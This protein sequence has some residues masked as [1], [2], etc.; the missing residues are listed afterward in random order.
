MAGAS[1]ILNNLCLNYRGYGL[2][3]GIM[4]AGSDKTGQR[5]FYIDNDG[6]RLEG[7]LFAVGS[8]G[9]FALGVI[10]THLKK[11]MKDEEAIDLGVRAIYHATHR[12]IASG[13]VCRV[14][15]IHKDGWTRVHDGLDVN[16][17]HWKF[18]EEKGMEIEDDDNLINEFKNMS[19]F[20]PPSLITF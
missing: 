15:H 1:K 6:T 11:D 14:Y 9:T 5:L 17:L 4:I 12:D 19:S 3:M 8:G 16:E 18:K 20:S 10:E 7:D 13:G 2:S